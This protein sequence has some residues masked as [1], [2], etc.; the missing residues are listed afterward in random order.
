MLVLSRKREQRIVVGDNVEITVVE[1][2]PGRVKLGIKAP[3]EVPVLRS[4]LQRETHPEASVVSPR[5]R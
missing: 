4:E 1:I 3:L 2:R 5:P